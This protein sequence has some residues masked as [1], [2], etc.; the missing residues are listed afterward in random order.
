VAD[1]YIVYDN[2]TK[3]PAGQSKDAAIHAAGGD[4]RRMAPPQPTHIEGP[5]GETVSLI[6]I[7]AYYVAHKNE[8]V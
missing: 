1:W 3:S 4:I 5:G 6:D 2:G 8:F 7:K